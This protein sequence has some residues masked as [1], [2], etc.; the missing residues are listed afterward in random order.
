MLPS[1]VRRVVGVAPQSPAVS[2]LAS[3]V[4]LAAAAAAAAAAAV[5][6]ISGRSSYKP[7]CHQRRYSSS[8]PSRPDDSFS[9]SRPSVPASRKRKAKETPVV[10]QLPSVPSTRHIKDGALALSTFFAL[11]R[12]ISVTKILPTSV[13]SD[14]FAEIFKYRKH[15]VTD[16]LSTLSQTVQDL[17]KPLSKL[18]TNANSGTKQQRQLQQQQQKQQQ[19]AAEDDSGARMIYQGHESSGMSGQFIPFHP[20]PPPRP[21]TDADAA[22]ADVMAAADQEPITRVYKA[23]VTIEEII[24]AD[25]QIK[26]LAHSPEMV[27]ERSLQPRTFL[28]RMALR[29]LHYE[30]A[31][32][33]QTRE[34]SMHAISVKRQRKLKMKKKKYKKLMRKTRNIRRK[35]DR[36]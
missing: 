34:R 29:Q 25:G 4:P 13:S 16:V 9:A 8:K 22:A 21:M 7:N 26:V 28:E 14:A 35:L 3:S 19:E 12:P 17:E 10:P 18:K 24:D 32:A 15:G 2:S 20:P 31:R 6:S 30:D 5:A 36:L 1:S 27:D 11:H 33:R 23:I